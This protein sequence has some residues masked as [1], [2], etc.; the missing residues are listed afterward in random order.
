MGH[1]EH[2]P[3]AKSDPRD[4]NMNDFRALVRNYL[5]GT[6]QGD[7]DMG[8]VAKGDRNE[9]VRILQRR[10]V[11]QSVHVGPPDIP[12]PVDEPYK[13]CDGIYGDWTTRAVA[14]FFGGDGLSFSTAE[15]WELLKDAE[16]AKLGGKLDFPIS[17]TGT[18][19]GTVS[20]SV[21]G[22]VTGSAQAK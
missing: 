18:V 19:S 21:S 7:D 11:R 2:Q 8:F 17:V 4:I 13:Y 14:T 16:D 20:G 22:S 3:G 5:D 9:K 6:A 10:L 12:T 1:K 15:Q